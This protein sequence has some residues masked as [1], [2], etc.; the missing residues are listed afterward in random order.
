MCELPLLAAS[1]F[2]SS[3]ALADDPARSAAEAVNAVGLELFR[4]TGVG[5]ANSCLSPYSIQ[6]AL[7]MAYAGAEGE[8]RDQ[9]REVLHYPESGAVPAFAALQDQISLLT[10]HSERLVQRVKEDGGSADPTDSPR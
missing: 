3:L 9:M 7:V 5:S 8:T 4:E 2:L 1:L 6:T 10:E